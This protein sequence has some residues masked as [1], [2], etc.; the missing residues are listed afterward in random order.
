M[1]KVLSQVLV[2]EQWDW[3]NERIAMAND[4]RLTGNGGEG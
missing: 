3:G 2:M 4:L 1:W